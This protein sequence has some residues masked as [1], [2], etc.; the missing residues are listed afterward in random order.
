MSEKGEFSPISR[1]RAFEGV[2]RQ[3]EGAI[4][5]GTYKIG[6]HLPSERELVDQFEVGRSTVREALRILESMGLVRTSQ[7]SR[8]GVEVAGHMTDSL[9]RILSGAIRL[10]NVP[11]VD[12]VEYRMM[13][14]ATANFLAAERKTADHLDD[15]SAAIDAMRDAADD[16][17]VFAS[18]DVAFHSA[19]LDAAGNSLLSMVSVVVEAAVIELI[20]QRVS[21]PESD[22]LREGFID[23]HVRLLEAIRGGRGAEAARLARASLFDTYAPSLSPEEQERLTAL[24]GV[25]VVTFARES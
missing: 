18:A 25:D 15:M 16:A 13:A 22:T 17:R 21:A 9:S 10:G 24:V 14:G 6:D 4:L 23:Q 12:L 8:K 19:I 5:D 11:L 1:D 20:A 2:V 7:G 3:I